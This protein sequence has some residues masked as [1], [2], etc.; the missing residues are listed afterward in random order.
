MLKINKALLV[1]L[2][3]ETKKVFLKVYWIFFY[4][5]IIGFGFYIG[6]TAAYLVL[7]YFAEVAVG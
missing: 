1:E 2:I 6:E 7:D 4:A 5:V 3:T